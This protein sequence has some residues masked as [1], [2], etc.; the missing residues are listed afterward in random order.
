MYGTD[1]V[2]NFLIR[3]S[4]VKNVRKIHRK[5]KSAHRHIDKGNHHHAKRIYNEIEIHYK[6]LPRRHKTDVFDSSMQ[7]HRRLRP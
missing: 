5:I 3:R 4:H 2:Q 7:L 6:N 1:T